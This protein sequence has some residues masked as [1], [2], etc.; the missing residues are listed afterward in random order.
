MTDKTIIRTAKRRR[1]RGGS[2]L[3]SAFL[4]PWLIFLYVGTF[5]WGYYAH[6]LISTE[7]AARV[8]GNFASY[9]TGNASKTS[10]VCTL[11]V[12]ELRIVP[13]ISATQTCGSTQVVN[14]TTA[15]VGPGQ[16]D[17]N[18]LYGGDLAAAVSITYT[19]KQLIPIPGLLKKQATF[20]RTVRMRVRN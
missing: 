6:A 9:N 14:V 2:A 5:D 20:Y 7:N 15:L 18:S 16:T 19:T 13:N 3:E 8:A 1:C 17:T 4:L 11:A 12:E 10:D